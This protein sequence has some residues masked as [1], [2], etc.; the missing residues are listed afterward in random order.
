MVGLDRDMLH[1][2]LYLSLMFLIL[3]LPY[4]FDIYLVLCLRPVCTIKRENYDM[5]SSHYHLTWVQ[6]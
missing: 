6:N 2:T 1:H 4:S 3:P 5:I